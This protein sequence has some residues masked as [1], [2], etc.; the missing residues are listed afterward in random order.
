MK[1]GFK[2]VSMSG[3]E[4]QRTNTPEG[5]LVSARI[6]ISKDACDSQAGA[7]DFMSGMLS[8][9]RDVI[10]WGYEPIPNPKVKGGL[11]HP[12]PQLVKIPKIYHEGDLFSKDVLKPV[13]DPT[14]DRL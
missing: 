13:V 9:N 4:Y 11:V 10:D 1:K 2:V 8:D 5:Y 12:M 3:D 7:C 6:L 14:A